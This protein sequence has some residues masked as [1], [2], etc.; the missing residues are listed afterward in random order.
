VRIA[1]RRRADAE[2]E[3]LSVGWKPRAWSELTPSWPVSTTVKPQP[4]PGVPSAA[5]GTAK[6]MLREI[7]LPRMPIVPSVDSLASTKRCPKPCTSISRLHGPRGGA[8]K[9]PLVG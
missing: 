6:V 8:W 5:F 7:A 9:S 4:G 2:L 3:A 1:A